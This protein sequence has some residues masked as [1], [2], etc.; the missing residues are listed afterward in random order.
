[1]YTKM[2]NEQQKYKERL[3]CSKRTR[4][5]IMIDCI[6]EFINHHPELKHKH[7]TQDRILERIALFYLDRT[8][9][10]HF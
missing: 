10:D 6:I 5:L 9:P 2:G 8:E 3:C 7:I 4:D 1:M